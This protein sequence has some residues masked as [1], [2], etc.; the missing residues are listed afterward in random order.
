MHD[1][2][3]SIQLTLRNDLQQTA[4]FLLGTAGRLD[5]GDRDGHRRG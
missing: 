5:R 3:G 4:K 2:S 1:T